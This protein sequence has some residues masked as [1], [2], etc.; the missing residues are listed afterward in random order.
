VPTVPDYTLEN[1]ETAHTPYI[2]QPGETVRI[3]CAIVL[4]ESNDPCDALDAWLELYGRNEFP[5]PAAPPRRYEE[6]II[7]SRQA[8]LTSCWSAEGKGWGHCVG[9]DPIPSGGMLALLS[10]DDFLTDK[11]G[12]TQI[13]KE[14]IDLV[15][16]HILKTRGPAG[17]VSSAGCH[18]MTFEPAF[19]WG[20]LESALSS[21]ARQA[22][23]LKNSQ[24]P[25]GSWGFHPSKDVQ[26][27][28]G[29]EGEVVSGTIA[30]HAMRLM[31]LARITAD[32]V[33]TETGLKAL[34][35]LNRR[36]VPRGAQGWECPLAAADI[37]VSGYGARANLDAYRI[38]GDKAYLDHAVYWARTGIVFH[39][40]WNLGGRPLQR[41]ATIPIFGTTFFSHSWLGV[42]VQ[43]CG[44][45][46]AYALQEL[47]EFDDRYPWL[48]IAEGIV[49]S[50]MHQQL[51]EGEL[52]GTLPDS[53]GDYF[54]TARG[55]YINPE[56][57]MTN[58]H[59]LNGNSLNIRTVFLDKPGRHAMRVS[60]N[61]DIDETKIDG[62]R[63]QFS[64]TSKPGRETSIVVAPLEQK[65]K[66]ITINPKRVLKE[67]NPL[68]GESSGWRYLPKQRAVL[69]RAKHKTEQVSFTVE[70]GD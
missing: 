49:N 46:Y 31:R 22:A 66:W 13:L 70:R 17:L 11:T 30:P 10:L 41:Y 53:Y 65:P 62:R 3:E 44:L 58:V 9:W 51:T 25:D 36:T 35:A 16:Q 42:P 56:N 19:Y 12:Q 15:Y 21:W 33:A 61:S 29:K 23:G 48:T 8:Y 14:R 64:L 18:V 34:E 55:A 60:A 52:I 28:L 26:K 37:M 47:A 20:V 27:D 1:H 45:V 32:P 38:T 24:N 5:L 69:I 6:E 40:L 7:L 43:W 67:A 54:I 2:I 57:I 63:I 4:G 50:A 39:Y 68:F 59:A